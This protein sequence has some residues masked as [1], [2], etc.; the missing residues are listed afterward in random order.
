VHLEPETPLIRKIQPEPMGHQLS[1]AIP[2]GNS[3]AHRCSSSADDI[4]STNGDFGGK[5]DEAWLDEGGGNG[6]EYAG[7][8]VFRKSSEFQSNGRVCPLVSSL[9]E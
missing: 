5:L 3:D 1:Q 2:S 7:Y 6:A 9:P 8:S 4:S